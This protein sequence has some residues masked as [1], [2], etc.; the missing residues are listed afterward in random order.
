LT[1]KRFD[2]I[3]YTH[4]EQIRKVSHDQ[5]IINPWHRQYLFCWSA[6]QYISKQ[7]NSQ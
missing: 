5:S 3:I 7:T 2:C 1:D 6:V 4:T